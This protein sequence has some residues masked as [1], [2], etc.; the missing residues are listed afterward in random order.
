MSAR[1]SFPIGIIVMMMMMALAVLGVGYAWWTEQLT[2]TG[3][4][5]TGSID[6]RMENTT[7]EEGDPLSVAT[8]SGTVS[9]DGKTLTVTIDNAYP[10]YTCGLNFGLTNYGTVP[11][12]ITGLKRPNSTTEY[13]INAAGE[14]SLRE[15]LNPAISKSASIA[16]EIL[17]GAA[18]S[19]N[20]RFDF[21]MEIAQGNAP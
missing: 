8:C 20:Y 7:V 2:A 18:Q 3:A 6:V 1:K 19:T 16:I 9:A 13:N 17:E 15:G 14:L 4:I 10:G 5:Q 11:A 21:S 12:K